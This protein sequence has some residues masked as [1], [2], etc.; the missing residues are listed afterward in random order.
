MRS[1]SQADTDTHAHKSMWAPY[2]QVSN[3]P[4]W[5][6]A[7]PNSCFSYQASHAY[8]AYPSSSAGVQFLNKT[9]PLLF[10]LTFR[11][12]PGG[13]REVHSWGVKEVEGEGG[14]PAVSSPTLLSPSPSPQSTGMTSLLDRDVWRRQGSEHLAWGGAPGRKIMRGVFPLLGEFLRTALISQNVLFP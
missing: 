3:I 7:V 1:G 13:G 2:P 14:K 5:Y 6:P 10:C 12:F 8:R 11:K 9:S 4:A